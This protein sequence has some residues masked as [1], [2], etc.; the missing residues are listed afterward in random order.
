M[1]FRDIPR[2]VLV[3]LVLLASPFVLVVFGPV[4]SQIAGPAGSVASDSLS[5]MVDVFGAL[6]VVCGIILGICFYVVS[7][8]DERGSSQHRGRSRKRNRS[9]C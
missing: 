6:S 9:W 4:I 1:N 5:Q 2:W 7:Q 8:L 3:L